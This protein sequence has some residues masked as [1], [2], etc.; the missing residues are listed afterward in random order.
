MKPTS[1]NEPVKPLSEPF[2]TEPDPAGMMIS[3]AV[4]KLVSTQVQA[5]L[6]ASPAF[7]ELPGARQNRI[8][9]DLEKIAAYTATLI[10]E[11]WAVSEKPD[12]TPVLH[13][14]TIMTA[15]LERVEESKAAPEP[16]P[17]TMARAQEKGAPKSDEFSPMAVG[18]VAQITRETLNS[19]AF[20]SFV[21]DLI[22]GTFQAIVDSSVQQMEAYADLLANVAK[23]VDQFMVDNI[24]DNNARDFLVQSFPGH[25]QIATEEGGARPRVRDEA[26][27]PAKPDLR[28]Y[29][30]MEREV[31]PD[32]EEVEKYLV[33]AV[34]RHLARNRHKVLSTMMLKGI[35]RIVVTSGRIKRSDRRGPV[36]GRQGRENAGDD[37][38]ELQTRE[39]I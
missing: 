35:N 36:V 25:F 30:S 26:E 22:K 17:V 21:A 9:E 16:V 19:V 3:P 34:R 23:T 13:Q 8:R 18:R 29:F 38:K 7:H 6:E 12:R 11:D 33:P 32:D 31:D 2:A 14:R 4:S 27:E 24:T 10:Q 15:S 37:G 20:P 1:R 5:L 39:R 28:D